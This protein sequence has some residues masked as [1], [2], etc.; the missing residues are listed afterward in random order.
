MVAITAAPPERGASPQGALGEASSPWIYKPWIDLTVGCGAWSAPLLLLGFYFANSYGR[1]WTLAFYFLALLSNYPH[2]MA[3][4]YRAYHTRDEFQK[5]RTYTVHVALLLAAAGVLTHLWYAMLPWV[6][7][8]Y[9]CWSPWHYTGQNFGLLMMFARRAGVTP[10]ERER[11][12]LRL[13]FIASYILLMLSF[14]TGPS[15]DTL[16]L[17]LG[18]P[19]TLTL[20]ARV[21]LVI[22]FMAA[23]G[24]ALISLA[25]RS[26]LWTMIPVATLA[27]TQFLWFL[28][29]AMIELFS[30]REIPQTRYSSG[31]LAVLHS[32]QYLWITSYYQKKEARA[33]GKTGWSYT[34]YL[35]TLIAGGIALFIPGPWIV[36]RVFHADFAA[37]FLT[38]TALV[39]IHHFI[40]D[41]AIWKLR[42]SRIASVLLDGQ[43]KPGQTS[44]GKRGKLSAAAGWIAGPAPGARAL[45][46]GVVAVLLV[47]AGMDQLHFW[48]SSETS[49]VS[50]LQKAA[51]M[52]PADSAV[53]VRLAN[54]EQSAGE[55]TEAVEAMHR[56]AAVNP[57]SL[58]LQEEYARSL[59]QAGDYDGAQA[60]FERILSRWPKNADA[61]VD[62]G[63]LEHRAGRDEAAIEDWQRAVDTA[64]GQPNAQLYLA[65]ALDQQGQLQA[66]A[67]HYSAYV[68]ILAARHQR[69]PKDTA[70]LLGALIRIGDADAAIGKTADAKKGYVSAAGFAEKAGAKTLE[71]LALAHLADLQE[72][73]GD[74]EGAGN[75]YQKALQL[76]AGTGDGS[77][78]ASDWFNYAEFLAHER[79]PER[80]VFACLLHAESLLQKTAG[81]ELDVVEQARKASEARVGREA[82]AVRSKADQ[83][84]SE[85]ATL[86]ISSNSL[87]K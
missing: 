44:A 55:S 76:D 1:A 35:V 83:I 56:A 50:A 57:G 18:L 3:T 62:L 72:K 43:Q 64:P 15:G 65:Q 69:D 47:W 66:A 32:T 61:L 10:T 21:A 70:P 33:A 13:S 23:S 38:F 74:A 60:Q 22:F 67:R 30:G 41:G 46:I 63:M 37:S 54:A 14:H 59:I 78:A 84:A 19:A 80:Y 81:K 28:L 71:S 20:P 5:Y 29:P 4:V 9:I 26:S 39:N 7:T 31:L 77:S 11:A 6:F 53:Q 58:A 73:Q 75:S 86:Q 24:W 40:L 85:A 8:L 34:G 79:Q 45:R 82:A 25:R 48:W 16:I 87:K 36:S 49:S 51:A 17:S 12:A 27:A 42:D 68:E 2:F 52:D